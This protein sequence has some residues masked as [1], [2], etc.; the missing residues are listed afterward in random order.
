[1]STM[2]R[3]LC[4]W[5]RPDT[6]LARDRVRLGA[7]L[8][9]TEN[10]TQAEFDPRT[11]ELAASCYTDHSILEYIPPQICNPS[12]GCSVPLTY[13]GLI[14]EKYGKIC[15]EHLLQYPNLFH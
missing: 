11:V 8:D 13:F 1:M 5:K 15:R 12:S 14:P 3:P 2:L 10:L 6:P 7:G 4:H 9:C